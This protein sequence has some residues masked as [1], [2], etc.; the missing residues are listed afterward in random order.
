MRLLLQIIGIITVFYMYT[1]R[2]EVQITSSF[3]VYFCRNHSTKPTP[4][5]LR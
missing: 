4:K 1:D 2:D 5:G 3:V